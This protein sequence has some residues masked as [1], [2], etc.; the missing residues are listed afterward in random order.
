MKYSDDNTKILNMTIPIQS[1]S[2][3]YNFFKMIDSF[4]NY[5]DLVSNKTLHKILKTNDVNNNYIKAKIYLNTGLYVGT[6]RKSIADLHDF[7]NYLKEGA[8]NRIKKLTKSFFKTA[9]AE[10]EAGIFCIFVHFLSQ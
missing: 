10:G 1:D 9:Q 5:K 2:N 6:E 8:K 7:Y 3:E 4:V